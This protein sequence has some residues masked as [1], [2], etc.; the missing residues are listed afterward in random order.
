MVRELTQVVSQSLLDV[1]FEQ[2]ANQASEGLGRFQVLFF[3][4]VVIEN[5][6]E[7]VALAVSLERVLPVEN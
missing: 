3:D 5:V 7:Q 4:H 1:L 6:E 2:L